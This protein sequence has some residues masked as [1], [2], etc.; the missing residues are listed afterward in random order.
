MADGTRNMELLAEE[1]IQKARE[2]GADLAGFAGVRDLLR[3]PSETLFPM[4]DDHTRDHFAEQI[5]TGLAHGAV[6]WEAGEQSVLVFAVRHPE[7]KPEMDWWYGEINPPGN[8]LLAEIAKK[9]KA[10]IEGKYPDMRVF[11]KP[12]H[13]EKGGIYLKDAAVAAG[14]GCIG[15][16]NLLVTPEY[17]PRV[18]LRAIGLSAPIP[19][20]GPIAFDPCAGCAAPCIAGCPREAFSE[21]VYTPEETGLHLLPGRIGTYRRKSCVREMEAN[22]TS[23]P[24]E[25]APA[26]SPEPIP[27]IRYC[28]NCEF[29]CV[30]GKGK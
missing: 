28:R 7:A 11:P 17:G 24:L 19:S 18:R 25:L 23:A 5:T 1:L 12:Y 22:E 14:L 26:V 29:N 8:K 9:L 20:G 6:K 2:F 27:V 30:I 15:K 3:G 16:N 10:Y 13:V 21:I 4:I